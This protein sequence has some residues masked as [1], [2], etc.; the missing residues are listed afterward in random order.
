MSDR[1][2]LMEAAL[3][4]HPEGIALLDA[5]GRVL[6]WNRSAEGITGFAGIEVVARPVP[7][8]LEPILYEET[9]RDEGEPPSAACARRNAMVRAQDKQGRDLPLSMRRLVLRD[10]LG[11]RIGAAILFHPA[12]CMDGLPHGEV[13]EHSSV[14][15]TQAN[16]EERVEELHGDFQRRG[17]PFGLL[18]MTVD[19]AHELRKTHG[20][21]ASEAMLD[22]MEQ[23]LAGG[24][25][26]AEELGRWGDDE[27][28]VLTHEQ[29]AEALGTH[30][31]A[32]GGL[33]RTTEFRWWGDRVSLT[34]SVG[35]A[36]AEPSETL[37]ELLERAQTAMYSSMHAGGNQVTLA[38]GRQTCSPS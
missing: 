21:R 36:Q 37:A 22:R 17:A 24:L 29:S 9:P 7:W 32:M 33:A 23:T 6:F 1:G 8:A 31:R 20:T 14:E 11:G 38:P 35:A 12:E 30:G 3:E 26:P 5:A 4:G 18:W 28:L 13:G 2:A 10:G 16:L 34:V 19:Q 15:A 27:F 25:L